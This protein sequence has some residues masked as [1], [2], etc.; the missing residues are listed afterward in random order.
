VDHTGLYFEADSGKMLVLLTISTCCVSIQNEQ[1]IRTVEYIVAQKRGAEIKQC[2]RMG[3]ASFMLFVKRMLVVMSGL[4][5][6]GEDTRDIVTNV[7]N[8]HLS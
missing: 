5:R 7:R 2:P 4:R 6:Q 8:L 1:M 3:D